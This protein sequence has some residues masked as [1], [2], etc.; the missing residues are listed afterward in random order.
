[1]TFEKHIMQILRDNCNNKKNK[2]SYSTRRKYYNAS[3]MATLKIGTL[4]A[5]LIYFTCV[6][7]WYMSEP[8][9]YVAPKGKILSLHQNTSRVFLGS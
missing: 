6:D 5:V 7:S 9:K 4:L 2:Y 3:I 8:T 1:M